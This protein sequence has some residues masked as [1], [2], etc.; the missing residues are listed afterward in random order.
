M[1]NWRG[2]FIVRLKTQYLSPYHIL[3]KTVRVISRIHG[4]T[5]TVSKGGSQYVLAQLDWGAQLKRLFYYSPFNAVPVT[6]SYSCKICQVSFFAYMMSLAQFQKEEVR[7]GATTYVD[8][9]AQLKRPFYYS[10]LNAVPVTISY[11]CENCPSRF[12]HTRCPRVTSFFIK[13]MS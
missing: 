5:C 2:Y 11:S 1:R 12:L 10:P 4:V 8:W 3:L 9:G 6:I 7:F 13:K